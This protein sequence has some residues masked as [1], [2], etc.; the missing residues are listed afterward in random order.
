MNNP[1]IRF[2]PILLL[3]ATLATTL[4]GCGTGSSPRE[5]VPDDSARIDDGVTDEGDDIIADEVR[6]DAT[7][8]LDGN[9]NDES[10]PMM[11]GMQMNEMDVERTAPGPM[12]ED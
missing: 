4:P 2:A 12:I 7:N 10:I 5:V 11:E 8:L 1:A 3:S 9:P 6:E